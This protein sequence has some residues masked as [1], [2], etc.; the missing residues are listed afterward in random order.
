M[1]E[2]FYHK[3]KKKDKKKGTEVPCH[4]HQAIKDMGGRGKCP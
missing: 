1:Y 4:A 3:N 2:I